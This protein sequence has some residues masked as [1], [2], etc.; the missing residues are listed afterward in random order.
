VLDQKGDLYVCDQLAPSVDFIEYP[1]NSVTKKL[2][3]DWQEP[4]HVT[5]SHALNRIYVADFGAADVKVIA[6]P[7]GKHVATLNA[8]NG[9]SLPAA[10]VDGENLAP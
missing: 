7:R 4:F 5:F 9:L 1:Y 3:S 2:G 6:I 10:A 8:S